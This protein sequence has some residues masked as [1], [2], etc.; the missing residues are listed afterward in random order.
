[1]CS[2]STIW[3][4]IEHLFFP[5][6]FIFFCFNYFS[7]LT[8]SSTICLSVCLSVSMGVFMSVCLS[9]CL[10]VC[11]HIWVFL[12]YLYYCETDIC[13]ILPSASYY[14][15]SHS[16]PLN[17]FYSNLLYSSSH[18]SISLSAYQFFLI[19]LCLLV[20]F[21]SLT[22]CSYFFP[23]FSLLS[24]GRCNTDWALCVRIITHYLPV[25]LTL[26]SS[27]TTGKS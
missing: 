7:L 14:S 9:V 15:R 12:F 26:W 3:L 11:M 17:S 27:T 2:W 21:A 25:P 5:Y 10:T 6:V 24:S 23:P 22:T 18:P 16:S 1:M 4:L 13:Y 20:F 8:F 19:T